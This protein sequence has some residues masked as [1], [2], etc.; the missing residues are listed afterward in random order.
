LGALVL[1]GGATDAQIVATPDF[2]GVW[3]L[4]GSKSDNSPEAIRAALGKTGGRSRDQHQ[5]QALSS[6]L[7][8]LA[9]ASETIE[10]EQ[11]SQDFTLINTED[12][13]RIHYIDGEKHAR[14]SPSGENMTTVTT[15]S[16]NLL[17]AATEGKEIGKVTETFGFEGLQLVHIVRIQHKLFEED[18]VVRTYYNRL[19]E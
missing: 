11:T 16:D 8:Y 2:S 10:I 18:L 1:V 13:V 17:S 5:R 14:Q 4:D 12:D 19:D 6:R 3:E 7:N 15:W 9:Y